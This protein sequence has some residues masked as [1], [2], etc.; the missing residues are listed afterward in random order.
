MFW[1]ATST[2]IPDAKNEKLVNNQSIQFIRQCK[3]TSSC[4]ISKKAESV[5][6]TVF[7]WVSKYC[8]TFIDFWPPQKS[9]LLLTFDFFFHLASSPD[10][11]LSPGILRLNLEEETERII[12]MQRLEIKCLREQTQG[13]E[14]VL[15]LRPLSSG[16]L[17]TLEMD[18][19][20]DIQSQWPG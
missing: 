1:N 9:C 20:R 19:T 8:T 18:K 13:Q 5:F 16:K 7:S 14:K 11:Q 15:A 12:Q 3:H 4:I 2:S 6:F 17:P 10:R